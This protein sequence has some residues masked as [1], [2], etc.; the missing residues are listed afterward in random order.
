MNISP[1]LSHLLERGWHSGL[2][3]WLDRDQEI[4]TFPL[5][6][7]SHAFVGYQKYKWN[8]EKKRDNGGKYFTWIT[9]KYRPLAFWGMEYLNHPDWQDG[10]SKPICLVCEGVWDAIRCQNA[11]YRAIAV[12]GATP[13]KIFRYWM[14]QVLA[15][16]TVVAVCDND[17]AGKSLAKLGEYAIIVEGKKDINEFSD[18]EAEKWLST[19]LKFLL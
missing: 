6:G 7:P 4:I 9:E 18:E 2:R 15:D 3:C 10:H 11:G 19:K 16:Y 17:K 5:W 14:L 8:E 1:F 13:N 12:L